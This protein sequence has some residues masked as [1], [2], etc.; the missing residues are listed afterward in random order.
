MF[1]LVILVLTKHI[2][3]KFLFFQSS[4]KDIVLVI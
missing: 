1:I 2:E 4:G 3:T